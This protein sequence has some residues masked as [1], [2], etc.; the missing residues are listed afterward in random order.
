MLMETFIT[1]SGKM[2]KP[3]DTAIKSMQ[4]VLH[5]KDTGLRIKG[6]EKA[7][8]HSLTILATKESMNTIRNMVT[9]N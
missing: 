9:A 4:T 7:N 8:R 5:I 2:I 1:E 3:M 6:T